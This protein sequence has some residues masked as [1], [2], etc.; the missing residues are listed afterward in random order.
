M[1]SQN[2]FHNAHHPPDSMVLM[3]CNGCHDEGKKVGLGDHLGTRKVR[4]N[5][6]SGSGSYRVKQCGVKIALGAINKREDC[7]QRNVKVKI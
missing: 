4:K 1:T 6:A 7:S 2:R 5:G 3:V